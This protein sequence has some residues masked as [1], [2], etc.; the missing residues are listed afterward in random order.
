[1]AH[2][3]VDLASTHSQSDYS[4]GADFDEADSD[5]ERER[6]VYTRKKG[7]TTMQKPERKE[8]AKSQKVQ[9]AP[10]PA[11]QQEKQLELMRVHGKCGVQ[12]CHHMH[13]IRTC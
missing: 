12:S 6:Q 2:S 5:V 9:K 7:T 11:Q 13:V 3:P 4:S 10:K 8:Q 1:M